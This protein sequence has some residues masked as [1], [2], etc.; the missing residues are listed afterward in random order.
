MK[1]HTNCDMLSCLPAPMK[2][3]S[4]TISEY[5]AVFTV[6]LEEALL[7]SKTVI[8]GTRKDPV[9]SKVYHYTLDGWPA[10][11]EDACTK[12]CMVAESKHRH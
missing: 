6:T 9:L 8:K 2:D 4:D 3:P 10:K 5:D 11:I 1:K 12:L 7:N